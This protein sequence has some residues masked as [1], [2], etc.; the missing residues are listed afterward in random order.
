MPIAPDHGQ[1]TCS[2]DKYQQPCITVLEVKVNKTAVITQN[3][4]TSD[5]N[6]ITLMAALGSELSISPNTAT[7]SDFITANFSY[8][9]EFKGEEQFHVNVTLIDKC[10]QQS[11]PVEIKCKPCKK[12]IKGIPFLLTGFHPVGGQGQASPPNSL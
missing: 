6:L 7:E 12:L 4:D 11:S 8:T 2:Y 5:I 1:I 9:D 10:G 3:Q